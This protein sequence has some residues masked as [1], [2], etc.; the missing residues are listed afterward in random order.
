LFESL[1]CV[2]VLRI[3]VEGKGKTSDQIMF[4]NHKT[5]LSLSLNQSINQSINQNVR[6]SVCLLASVFAVGAR[7][8]ERGYWLLTVSLLACIPAR[9]LSP[10]R[11]AIL[12][13]NL[14]LTVRTLT[15]QRA[16]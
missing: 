11:L 5:A 6:L 14:P 13:I 10:Y 8:R 15:I 7:V 16:G 1:M 4:V 3:D 12:P 9:L 2:C